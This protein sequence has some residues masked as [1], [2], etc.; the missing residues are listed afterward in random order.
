MRPGKR[1]WWVGSV[2]VHMEKGKLRALRRPCGWSL[3]AGLGHQPEGTAL[4]GSLW[5]AVLGKA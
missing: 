5:A 4:A 1:R 2:A 3:G